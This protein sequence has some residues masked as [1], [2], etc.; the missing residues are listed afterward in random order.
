MSSAWLAQDPADLLEHV[1]G[2]IADR[3]LAESLAAE[4][5]VTLR[6]PDV[7]LPQRVAHTGVRLHRHR[8]HRYWLGLGANLGDRAQHMRE[9][10]GHL[11]DHGV[12]VEATSPVYET[13]PQLV[14]D[15]PAFLNAAA[16]VR[17]HLSPPR[18]LHRIRAAERAVGRVPGPRFGPRAVDCDVLLWDGG[19]W[20]APELT[21]PHPRLRDRRFALI[22]LLDLDPAPALPDGTT[23][24]AACAA[25]PEAEQAVVRVAA[26]LH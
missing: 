1:A 9:L 12:V 8:T 15:Q 6:K 23:L 26:D 11:R 5:T 3:A 16:R 21:V 17:T 19:V 13:A 4:V 7:D 25:L 24:A 22:P 10:L 14:V 2:R 20:D 18:L